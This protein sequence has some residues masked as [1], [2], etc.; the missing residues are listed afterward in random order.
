MLGTPSWSTGR[1]SGG[2]EERSE[3]MAR[4]LLS[5]RHAGRASGSL[6]RIRQST[7]ACRASS[8]LPVCASSRASVDI[9]LPRER[10]LS[11]FD[12]GTALAFALARWLLADQTP[13]TSTTSFFLP[14]WAQ[15][16]PSEVDRGSPRLRDYAPFGRRHHM[17]L[18]E[19]RRMAATQRLGQN[20]TA[21]LGHRTT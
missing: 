12:T 7:S 13:W 15:K 5:S 4:Q 18:N 16:S 9:D 21:C 19:S 14:P 17:R 1:A 2:S 6:S 8:W 10:L 20:T 11:D 3:R